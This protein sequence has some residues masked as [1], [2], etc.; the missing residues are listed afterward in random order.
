MKFLGISL[1]VEILYMYL[2]NAITTRGLMVVCS[3]I[4]VLYQEAL[5]HM[6]IEQ[7]Q[8]LGLSYLSIA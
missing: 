8:L 2:P 1:A 4:S 5:H 3:S 6:V 7:H